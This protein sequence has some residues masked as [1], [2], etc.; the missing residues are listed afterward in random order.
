MSVTTRGGLLLRGMRWRLGTSVLTVLTA[1]I[2][3]ATAVLGPLYLHTA[4]DSVLRQ[5][6][7]RPPCR[8]AA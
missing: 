5:T 6:S 8:I 7:R 3:V 2:A 4:G 1:T